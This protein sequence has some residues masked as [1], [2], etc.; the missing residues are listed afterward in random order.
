MPDQ[1]HFCRDARAAPADP[2]QQCAIGR[3][4]IVANLAR[5]D[6]LAAE[7]PG[8]RRAAVA[9][10]LAPLES[11]VIGFILTKRSYSLRRGAG[12]YALPGGH[13]EPGETVA[14]AALRELDEELGVRLPPSSEIGMLDD[15][16]TRSGHVVT[17]IVLW[18]E[19]TPILV[20]APAEVHA[21]WLRPL[22]DLAQPDTPR[23]RPGEDG[24]PAIPQMCVGGA[25]INP[26]T[27]AILYQFREVALYGRVIR[28]A[29]V[30]QPSWTAR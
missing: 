29:D 27:A 21:A 19:T 3:A 1:P 30:G 28:V 4:Q 24:G 2:V 6:R 9:I 13:V 18:A 11:D 15:L 16:I 8:A 26:P 25:W 23:W 5:F 10:T 20:P 14:A 7:Q 12:Q 17:P 22:D